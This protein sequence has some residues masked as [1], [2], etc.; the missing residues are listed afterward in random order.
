MVSQPRS[1][2]LSTTL[3]NPPAMEIW[4]PNLMDLSLKKV[5]LEVKMKY[6]TLRIFVNGNME[7]TFCLTNSD[8]YSIDLSK[9][10]FF[11]KLTGA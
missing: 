10:K 3:E 1:F 6:M 2:A 11:T 8:G 4:K 9:I 7:T 5:S